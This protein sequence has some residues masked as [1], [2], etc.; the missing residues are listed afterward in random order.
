MLTVHLLN[1]VKKA[2]IGSAGSSDVERGFDVRIETRPGLR[3]YR[4]SI[5]WTP[6]GWRTVTYTPC[7]LVE[8]RNDAD[9]WA[10][11]MS[12][13]STPQIS[14][15]YAVAAAGPDG[16]SWDNNHGWNYQI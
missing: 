4:V 15:Y 3:A 12:Y 1:A 9:I 13:Y 7:D 10:A 11:S 6:N 14:F 5:A 2:P 8:V 16:I